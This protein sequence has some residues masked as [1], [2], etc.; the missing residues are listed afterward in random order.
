MFDPL[1]RSGYTLVELVVLL[2][3][4]ALLSSLAV[5]SFSRTISSFRTRAAL[6][7]LAGD[8]YLARAMALESGQTITLR[9]E[10]PSGCARRYEIVDAEGTVRK[11]VSSDLADSGVCLESNVER[12][13]RVDGRGLLVGSPR[14]IRARRGSL[15]D[16]M[17]ISM[18]GRIYRW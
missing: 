11:Q 6:A 14:T 3:L 17:T 15:T 9:F 18:V 4:T 1:D 16:S 12:P 5:P 10:P 8:L 13:I 2:V 7:R